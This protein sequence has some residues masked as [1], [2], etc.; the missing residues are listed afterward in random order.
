MEDQRQMQHYRIGDYAKYMGVTPDLLKHYEE[1]GLIRSE[2]AENGYRYYPFYTSA[3]LLE[4]IRLRNYGMTL[5]EIAHILSD[6]GITDGAMN[7]KL[8]RN[9]ELLRE[10]IS[11]N[12]LL[13]DDYAFCGRIRKMLEHTDHE[14]IIRSSE[15]I[16]FLPHTN[17][18]VFLPDERIYEIIK[19]WMSYVPVVKSIMRVDPERGNIWGLAARRADLERLK[20][21]VNDAVEVLPP[22]KV[23]IYYSKGQ[24][25]PLPDEH[26]ENPS[27]PV[28]QLLSSLN[29]KP[30]GP[31]YRVV[32]MPSDW[33]R[34]ASHQYGLY[35]VPIAWR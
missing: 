30:D 29:L 12:Q 8:E 28:M 11:L 34:P 15:E 16:C 26:A 7:N 21:P 17:G 27:H 20:I 13:L 32:L 10:E 23:L 25:L 31:Y 18:Y 6:N 2:R 3:L 14:W 24:I 4:C 22:K 5:R 35:V 19:E 33:A 1:L 9:M